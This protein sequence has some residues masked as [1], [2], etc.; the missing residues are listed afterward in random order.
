MGVRVPAEDDIVEDDPWFSADQIL[1]EARDERRAKTARF[2]RK[3]SSSDEEDD[4]DMDA[5]EM[6]GNEA[7]ENLNACLNDGATMVAR[8][9]TLSQQF[10]QS[11]QGEDRDKDREIH[12][13]VV[14]ENRCEIIWHEGP[15]RRKRRKLGSDYHE[16]VDTG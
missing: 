8:R 13:A 14:V 11:E 12:N 10:T 15:K 9:R 7:T 5:F 6:H 3:A 16:R 4:H 1:S 2:G